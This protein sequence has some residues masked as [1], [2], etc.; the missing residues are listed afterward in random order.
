MSPAE[1]EA[2]RIRQKVQRAVG[3]RITAIRKAKGLA[4]DVLA[5]QCGVSPGTLGQI[6]RGH[7]NFQLITLVAIAKALETTVADLMMG[8]A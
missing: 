2:R 5:R 6:E 1:K 4:Q 7:Q 8:I 3:I